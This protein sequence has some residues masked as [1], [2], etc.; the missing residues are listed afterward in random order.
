MVEALNKI[1]GVLCPNPGGAFYSIVRL[2]IDDCDKFCTW[3]LE[4]FSHE[5][6]TVMMAPANGFYATPGLGQ[7]EVRIAYVL[8]KED[9]AKA[10]ECLEVA[11]IKYPGRTV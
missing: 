8:K 10:M 9:L 1:K 11:L 6:Q 2:P 5:G 7:N 3:I 4:S